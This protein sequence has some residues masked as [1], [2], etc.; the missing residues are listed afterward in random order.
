M[1]LRPYLDQENQKE[2]F[3][4]GLKL[5]SRG[6]LCYQPFIL[7]DGVEVGEGQNLV[8]N[9][10]GCQSIFDHNVYLAPE[11]RGSWTSDRSLAADP[12]YFSRCNERYRLCYRTIAATISAKV[13]LPSS[14]I[15]EVGCNAGLTLFYLA[16]QGAARCLGIDST[17]Y[18]HTFRWLNTV[19]GTRVQFQRDHYDNLM[20]A[21]RQDPGRFDVVINTVFLNHQSD[22]LHCLAYLARRAKKGLFLWVLLNS[23]EDM[24]IRYGAVAGIHDLGAG[25]PFP[26]SFGNDVSISKPLL[27]ESLRALGFADVMF[28]GLP[29]SSELT[30][31]DGITAFTMLYA[32]R[33]TP[34]A[35]E[36]ALWSELWNQTKHR[37]R[38]V[39]KKF[40]GGAVRRYARA[41]RDVKDTE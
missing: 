1:D 41:R 39:D 31:P 18:Q 30:V 23:S 12:K 8:E 34:L 6:D 32:S 15:M 27:L 10:R 26:T 37:I 33:T 5:I 20:H 2:L 16:Q 3:Q 17:D 21:L 19:L 29:Q 35:E 36:P 40:L 24:V 38:K 28:V 9:Y 14:S 25:R 13:D 4:Q 11:F 7:A 22:P